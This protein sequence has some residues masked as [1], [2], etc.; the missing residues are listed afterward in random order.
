MAV[1]KEQFGTSREGQVLSLYTM[2]NQKGMRVKIT[3]LGAALVSVVLADKNGIEKDV[4]LGYDNPGDYYKN[5]CF[6]GAVIGRSGNRIDKG[7]FTINGKTYQLDI[8]DN[9]NNLH[10]GNDS[11][12][13]R[14]WAASVQEDGSVCFRIRDKDGQQG[15]PGNFEASITYT[16][17]DENELFLRYKGSCDQDT[18]ANMTNHVYF[19][20]AGH[21]SGTILDQKLELTAKFYTPVRDSQ[22]IPTGEIAPV[23]GTPMDFT[24][25]KPIGK[26]IDADFR[27]LQY[28][29]GYD[30]NFVIK[31][32][33][34]AV[35]KFAEAYSSK[36]G[37]CLE[38]YTDLPGVQFYAGNFI[39]PGQTGK[40]GV[41]YEKRQ[42]FCLE[43]QYY[44]NS[45]NQEGFASP[46]LKAGDIYETTTCYKFSLK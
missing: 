37:I 7:R 26:E 31:K 42:G 23:A 27:Q 11:F 25:A 30:H 14:Q 9:E 15:Y 28:V 44:P 6:F 16:L 40:G 41:T 4:I 1:V 8:N 46:L 24:E 34:G 35:E 12:D 39:T 45:I 13:K 3:D 36:T 22:A 38:A 20:L 21:D 2:T 43:S 18:V 19:N 17:T 32:S 5:T 29:G 10:S 33:K